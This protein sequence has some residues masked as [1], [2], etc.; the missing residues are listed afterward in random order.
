MSLQKIS[1][2]EAARRV[3]EGAVIVD[4]RD[5]DEHARARIP[6]ARNV[7]V[8]RLERIDDAPVVIYHCKSGGRTDAN[9]AKLAQAASQCEA[10][11]LEGGIEAWRLAGLPYAEDRSQPMEIMRQVQIAAGSLVLAGIILGLAVHPGFFGLAAFVGAGLTFAGLSGWC[12]M[13]K[14]L[15]IMPW[16]R[17][18]QVA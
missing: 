18:A 8:G 4:I 12:G 7:P 14:M 6:G 3:A 5:P 15:A 2:A 11:I 16:N 1:P 13:A 17:R 9:A 10:F